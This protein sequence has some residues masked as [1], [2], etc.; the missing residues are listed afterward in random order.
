MVVSHRYRYVFI[1][2]MKTASSAVAKELCDNYGGEFI[3]EK[4]DPIQVFRSQ[5]TED[6][7]TYFSFAGV[8][9]PLDVAV[10]R[11]MV[12]KEG[13]GTHPQN[14]KQTK[15]IHDNNADFNKFFYEFMIARHPKPSNI[16][17]VPR[18]WQGAKFQSIDYIYKYENLQQEFSAIL[19]KLGI[20]QKRALPLLN[21]TSGKTDYL[22][23][24]DER[25]LR[26]ASVLCSDYMQHWGYELPGVITD[27]GAIEY[28]LQRLEVLRKLLSDRPQGFLN[29][30]LFHR[31][32]QF[33]E[34]F[35]ALLDEIIYSL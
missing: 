20:E 23:Y 15:F 34:E 22:D 29:R 13:Q 27:V 5:A 28:K 1:Q 10:S 25:T 19:S 33:K 16:A 14:I 12:R 32:K 7:K 2:T 4:H 21:Q 31:Q 18:D 24:Y 26:L 17:I 9:N 11:Y 30:I 35:V 8:R 6:E 3:F